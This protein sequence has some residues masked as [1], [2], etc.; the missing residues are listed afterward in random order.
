MCKKRTE[1][2]IKLASKYKVETMDDTKDIIVKGFEAVAE[3]NAESY[4][5]ISEKMK[6]WDKKFENQSKR[7]DERF[8]AIDTNLAQLMEYI[9]KPRKNILSFFSSK[10]FLVSV[11]VVLVI[12]MLSG[13]GVMGLLDRSSNIAEIVH[14]TK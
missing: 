6:V 5:E 13:I 9:V 7:I 11:I 1:M 14:S 10:K 8:N 12:T 2:F 4:R 3:D